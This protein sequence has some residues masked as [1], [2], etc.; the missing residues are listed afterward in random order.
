M[1]KAYSSAFKIAFSRATKLIKSPSKIYILVGEVVKKIDS[2]KSSLGKIKDELFTLTR[3]LKFWIKGNYKN[4]STTSIITVVGSLIYF[5]NPLD[6][7]P[8]FTP[9]FGFT[10]DATILFYVLNKIGKE[11]K[12]FELWEKS[13]KK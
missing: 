10:D 3:L 1:N 2:R 6:I 8:D 9:I 11:I 4:I 13:I 7:I 5:V 12:E